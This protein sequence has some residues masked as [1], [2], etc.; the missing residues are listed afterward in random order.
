MFDIFDFDMSNVF[1]IFYLIAPGL[2]AVT[3]KDSFFS[4]EKNKFEVQLIY[5]VAFS[6]IIMAITSAI[7]SVLL[8][9]ISSQAI[10]FICYYLVIGI[11]AVILGL[12]TMIIKKIFNR[13]SKIDK[14]T[15]TAW[16]Y[17]FETK[18]EKFLKLLL[19]VHFMNGD[20]IRGKFVNDS[21]ASHLYSNK[22][23]FIEVKFVFVSETNQWLES[24]SNEWVYFDYQE[25]IYIRIYEKEG[26]NV[27]EN[28]EKKRDTENKNSN[29]PVGSL[30][31]DFR[32]N[33]V[34]SAPK[35]TNQ[36]KTDSKKKK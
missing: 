4:E 19:E 33:N 6:F 29:Q 8:T 7:M 20:I 34:Y 3:I 31:E 14:S 5:Y 26:E 15:P 35:E 18:P 13:I 9:L 27:M 16:N 2:V 12:L 17:I 11:L 21:K 36:Q 23:A 32:I 1:F 30:N 24:Q 22:D 25:V 28:D 10:Q